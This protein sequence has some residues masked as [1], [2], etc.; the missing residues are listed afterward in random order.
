MPKTPKYKPGQVTPSPLPGPRLAA[1]ATAESFGAAGAR[2]LRQAGQALE[3]VA[4]TASKYIIANQEKANNA[5]ARDGLFKFREE[6][7]KR[8][9]EEVFSRPGAHALDAYARTE[10]IVTDTRKKY[11]TEL[12]NEKQ[13]E[14]FAASADND[15]VG[16][17]GNAISFQTQQT[18]KFYI[19]TIQAGIMQRHRKAASSGRN[20]PEALA[21]IEKEN[22]QDIT[23][24]LAMQGFS[25]EAAPNVVRDALDKDRH[26]LY[27]GVL[28]VVK[29][30]SAQAGLGFFRANKDKF[31][32][33]A[34]KGEEE[35]LLKKV[36]SENITNIVTTIT[37]LDESLEEQLESVDILVAGVAKAGDPI[38]KR[39]VDE[40]NR[41]IKSKF[42]ERQLLKKLEE[43]KAVREMYD[44]FFADIEGY[45]IDE[46]R[47][48]KEVASHMRSL[49]KAHL[50]KQAWLAGGRA[51]PGAVTNH[52][53]KN[54]LLSMP[55]PELNALN[56]ITDSDWAQLDA[57][58][59]EEVFNHS[60]G[61]K[62]TFKIQSR[63]QQ[64]KDIMDR[65]D[66]LTTGVR[67]GLA[68]NLS[69][70]DIETARAQFAKW[71][72]DEI[73]SGRLSEEDSF[74]PIKL[75]ERAGVGLEDVT[76]KVPVSEDL[77]DDPLGGLGSP[78]GFIWHQ[79]QR[80]SRTLKLK[81]FE[82]PFL[83]E[84]TQAI[85]D[86]GVVAK[87]PESIRGLPGLQWHE[88]SKTYFA[89][90]FGEIRVFDAAGEHIN[91]FAAKS[92]MV[93]AQ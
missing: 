75:R 91:T 33:R 1:S 39:G 22:A 86:K 38:S 65:T 4:A 8:L 32:L 83:S 26:M 57:G 59:W 24:V 46:T 14:L 35:S 78:E 64:I 69:E 29:L 60:K 30:D 55:L 41:R 16:H 31:D 28:D 3:D 37:S 49:R 67:P 66:L 72:E 93:G 52:N 80:R 44:G 13:K 50:E 20:D 23:A 58:D 15:K 19:D 92:D 9:A 68:R 25:K 82:V 74:D 36:E 11:I 45:Q 2:Q 70:E 81:R 88:E 40:I 87:A 42:S 27:S 63:S 12:K 84:K 90:V 48:P 10:K 21:I 54:K 85:Y 76:V 53:S 18:R 17:L 5:L 79:W 71:L 6:V 7:E 89:P 73:N 61:G 51:K 62:D 43:D 47:V 56:K 34:M 77:P